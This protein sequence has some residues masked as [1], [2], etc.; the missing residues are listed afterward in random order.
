MGRKG[1]VNGVLMV[2]IRA[3]YSLSRAPQNLELAL[4]SGPEGPRQKGR[5][6]RLDQVRSEG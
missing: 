3:G 4:E 2:M 1:D 6:L 5:E